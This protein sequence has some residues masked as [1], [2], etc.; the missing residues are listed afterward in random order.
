MMTIIKKI[1]SGA[2]IK[3]AIVGGISALTEYLLYFLFKNSLN[4]LIANVL[5]FGLTNIMT[6]AL[7]RKYVFASGNSN[8]TEEATLYV[9]CLV[10]AL[11]VNQVVLWGLVEFGAMDD[12]FAK[13]VA[14]AITVFWNYFTRKHIVFKNR[15]VVTENSPA[16]NYPIK[17]F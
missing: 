17:R 12:K 6:F 2:F 3:F 1:L 13:A 16:K 4:Y 10:G 8:K 11:C 5:A 14:I 9:I 7:S 15:E